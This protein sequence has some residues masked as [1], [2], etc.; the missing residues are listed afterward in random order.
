M[1]GY[2]TSYTGLFEDGPTEAPQ[3]DR[4]EIPLIQRDYA[5]GR[6]GPFVEEIRTNFLEVLL[7]A[8]AGGEPVGLDFVYGSVDTGV[9]HPLDGQQ[10]LTTLFLLHWYLAATTD[11]LNEDSK[12]TAFSYATRPS[13]RMFC[14]RLAMNNFP[15]DGRTLSEWI[16]DQEWYLYTW[17]NDPTIQSMLVMLD[18]IHIGTQRLHPELDLQLAW[19]R[20]TDDKDP[21]VSFCLLPLDDMYSH[22]DLYIKMNSRGRPLTPFETFK[23]RFE[24]DIQHLDRADEFAHKIDGA[25]ADLL[26]PY[27]GDDKIVDDEL[28]RYLDFITEICELREARL[29]TGH[30]G[31]RAREV[32]GPENERSAEHLDFLFA[33]FDTW[34]GL[35]DIGSVFEELFS[36]ALPGSEQYDW[37]RVV[38]FGS[39]KTNLFEQCCHQF[40]SQRPGNRAFTLQQSLLLYA[41]LLHR[42]HQTTDFPRRLR[43]TRNLI[44][45]SEDEVRRPKMPTLIEDVESVILHGDMGSVKGFSSN[46]IEDERLKAEFLGDHPELADSV[47]RLE[48]HPLLR[49]S[50]GAFDLEVDSF[51]RRATAFE[52]AFADP[53]HWPALTG[54]LLATGDYQ[55]QRPNSTGWQFGTGSARNDAVWRYLLTDAPRPALDGLRVVLGTFLDGVSAKSAPLSQHLDDVTSQWLAQ[56]E[57]AGMLDWR[58]YLVKYVSMRG[59]RTGAEGATGIYFGV[60]GELGYSMI[61]LRTKQLNGM[62][63]DPFLLEVWRS[64]SVGDKVEDPWFTGYETQPRWLRLARS[65]VGLRCT[66]AGFAIQSPQDEDL[67]EAFDAFCSTRED[68]ISLDDGFLLPIPQVEVGEALVDSTDRIQMGA[69]LLRDLVE[70]GL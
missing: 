16:V 45:A 70:S 50:L 40:D 14:E 48:D 34:Q 59:G 18:A 35:H 4:I 63:R 46:Q 54:A 27:R 55:R 19:R 36:D 52:L 53:G 26:W 3:I 29:A 38:P 65:G 7:A 49:G 39:S 30:L 37:L 67:A 20:L 32:F 33:A 66:E 68:L 5:Q 17:R 22:E 8:V 64:S 2:V 44:A 58:Y 6:P 9:L 23:A 31:A 43:V 10:R 25:W 61:M 15:R 42:I 12:W 28:M 47:H 60:G 11:N 69:A 57:T 51:R 62:Y 21:A 1:K 56:R 13:A 24:Q 41:V